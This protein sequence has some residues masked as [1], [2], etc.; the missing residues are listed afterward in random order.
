MVF[1]RCAL[2]FEHGI[3]NYPF[4][5]TRL[6]LYVPDPS[7][8]YFQ[9]RRSIGHYRLITLLDGT[10]DDDYF[11]LDDPKPAGPGAASST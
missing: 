7:A 1:E 10:T 5:E 8:V 9:G 11:I 6:G 3:L 2:V 4:V